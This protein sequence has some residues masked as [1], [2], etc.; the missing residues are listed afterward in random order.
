MSI[1]LGRTIR[2]AARFPFKRPADLDHWVEGLR[3]A[4]RPKIRSNISRVAP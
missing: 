3:K 2:M 1:R 4:G